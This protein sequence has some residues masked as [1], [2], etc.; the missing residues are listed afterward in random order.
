MQKKTDTFNI[1]GEIIEEQ[2]GCR[3]PELTVEQKKRLA[4]RG[5]KLNEFLL[6]QIEN[7]FAPSTILK[8]YSELIAKKYNSTDVNQ[9]KT[10]T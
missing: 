5:K 8:W 3:Q 7:T 4:H 9:K 6:G 1:Q 10:G 2:T